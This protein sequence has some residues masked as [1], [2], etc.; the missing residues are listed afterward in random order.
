MIHAVALFNL[1]PSA[2]PAIGNAWI[3]QNL[4]KRIYFYR[5][6]LSSFWYVIPY[7]YR[8]YFPCYFPLAD[9]KEVYAFKC[10]FKGS[11]IVT[12]W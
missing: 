3:Y 7:T 1:F 12:A 10:Q 5:F 2:E 9:V 6:Q 8:N 11:F 4:F